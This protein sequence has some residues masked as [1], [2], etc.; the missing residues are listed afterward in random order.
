MIKQKRRGSRVERRVEKCTHCDM[1]V[2]IIRQKQ[3]GVDYWIKTERTTKNCISVIRKN[4]NIFYEVLNC[5]KRIYGS[6]ILIFPV[7]T[8]H[9]IFISICNVEILIPPTGEE[10]IKS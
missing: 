10:F 3:E 9:K 5:Q 1:E 6:G 8:C 7:R 2:V 4:K